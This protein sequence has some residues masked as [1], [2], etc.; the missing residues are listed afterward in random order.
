MGKDR[1]RCPITKVNRTLRY[2]NLATSGTKCGDRR[3]TDSIPA[4][5]AARPT[6]GKDVPFLAHE[7]V[8]RRFVFGALPRNFRRGQKHTRVRVHRPRKRRIVTSPCALRAIPFR[9]INAATLCC[10]VGVM[11]RVL[12][13]LWFGTSVYLIFVQP[14]ATAL[15]LWAVVVS[16]GVWVPPR[17]ALRRAEW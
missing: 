8:T 10:F 12:T 5:T 6:A 11:D 16:K 2:R 15:F 14:V 1:R 4:I 9:K 13:F 7:H 17:P 3:L